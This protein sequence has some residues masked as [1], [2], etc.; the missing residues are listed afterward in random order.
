M[1][2]FGNQPVGKPL[3]CS[4]GDCCKAGWDKVYQE[5]NQVDGIEDVRQ[6]NKKIS[7][8]YA[9]LYMAAPEL[10]WAGTAA[11]ASKQVGCAMGTAAGWSWLNETPLTILGA[12]NLAVYDELY[13]PLRFYQQ[14]KGVL[15]NEQILKCMTEKPGAPVDPQILS[16]LEQIM[17]GD[18]IGG[19]LAMLKHEQEDTLQKAVYDKAWIMRRAIDVGDYFGG[20]LG[21]MQLVFDAKCSSDDS[22][23]I[24]DFNDDKYDDG[25]LFVFQDRWPFAQDCA[26]KFVDLADGRG[27]KAA[28]LK[29][30]QDIANAG[31]KP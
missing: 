6:R 28:I 10:K 5:V 31:S 21:S 26:Q 22:G 2:E 13:P 1:E 16:G 23:L 27:T 30:L 11:F 20:W 25:H 8:S 15:D 12:G 9:E 29:S 4:A 19:S 3:A 17:K 18:P 24:V 14:N 7:A